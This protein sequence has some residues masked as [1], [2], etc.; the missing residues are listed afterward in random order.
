MNFDVRNFSPRPQRPMN[1]KG[2]DCY[3]APAP[4]QSIR[5]KFSSRPTWR[6]GSMKLLSPQRQKKI[7]CIS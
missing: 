5:L 7:R 3:A 2:Y 1:P 4:V 6:A